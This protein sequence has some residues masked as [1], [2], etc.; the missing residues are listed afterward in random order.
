MA[1]FYVL[2]KRVILDVWLIGNLTGLTPEGTVCIPSNRARFYVLNKRV[3][4]DVW[5]M[6]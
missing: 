1:R 5:L 3:M 4:L 2:N 6:F